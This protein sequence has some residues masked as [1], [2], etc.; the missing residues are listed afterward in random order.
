MRGPPSCQPR[1]STNDLLKFA[2]AGLLWVT[3]VYVTIDVNLELLKNSPPV[4]VSGLF[5][6]LH[7][8]P[9]RFQ[10]GLESMALWGRGGL[11]GLCDT[12]MGI[13]HW[14]N[15]LTWAL[16]S[17]G[18]HDLFLVLKLK[19]AGD[20][21]SNP[22]PNSSQ[23]T[24]S[25]KAQE[26]YLQ[27]RARRA[28]RSQAREE[29]MTPQ[30]R[31]QVQVGELSNAAPST[32]PQVTT[33]TSHGTQSSTS[34]S[35]LHLTPEAGSRQ[36]R[37]KI[38]ISRELEEAE[39]ESATEVHTDEDQARKE[40]HYERPVTSTPVA[41]VAQ[42][43]SNGS[44]NTTVEEVLEATTDEENAGS[45]KDMSVEIEIR[46]ID[47]P[48]G[49]VEHEPEPKAGATEEPRAPEEDSVVPERP[50]SKTDY[51]HSAYH[52]TEIPEENPT[53]VVF[54]SEGESPE[55]VNEKETD[56]VTAADDTGET[57]EPTTTVTTATSSK[58]TKPSSSRAADSTV[59]T[60]GESETVG[61]GS[62]STSIHEGKPNRGQGTTSPFTHFPGHSCDYDKT[63]KA[64]LTNENAGTAEEYYRGSDNGHGDCHDNGSH[65]GDKSRPRTS[66][67]DSGSARTKDRR[68]N[69][70]GE[71][72]FTEP[73]PYT[74]A[75]T[76]AN[77][78][79]SPR[80][81]NIP[82]HSNKSDTSMTGSASGSMWCDNGG[83]R[84][85]E[86]SNR[87][88]KGGRYEHRCER[89]R[90]SESGRRPANITES[91]QTVQISLARPTHTLTL[92]DTCTGIHTHRFTAR[93]ATTTTVRLTTNHTQ[94]ADHH[95][96]THRLTRTLHP[97]TTMASIHRGSSITHTNTSSP[98]SRLTLQTFPTPVEED[99]L[100]EDKVT[101]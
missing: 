93:H 73:N 65:S 85:R 83:A 51:E 40:E 76:A 58:V 3:A 90:E 97:R 99:M 47:G 74:A 53:S 13:E 81:A 29:S 57:V 4:P 34:V 49:E 2:L 43:K 72:V 41:H 77:A 36:D 30:L 78:K 45:E 20:I 14:H 96:L 32:T 25:A 5:R 38:P 63:R 46:G 84:E 86:C 19:K 12:Y 1:T 50:E 39:R 98:T 80:R 56:D 15:R 21:E 37:Y 24:Q 89:E 16:V 88:G 61:V 18:I 17:Y 28:T 33:A 60:V 26:K 23:H 42:T 101:R 6:N 54:T 94:Q 55:E 92:T 62:G 8:S 35:S 64:R 70:D 91:N 68:P 69:A 87:G 79:A 71:A 95:I 27:A 75:S 100:R 10:R 9:C 44:D 52:E 48:G 82:S 59:T 66:R 11:S 67:R 7:A 31:S 22:G